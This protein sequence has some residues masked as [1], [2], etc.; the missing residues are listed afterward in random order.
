MK[1]ILKYMISPCDS[2]EA[3]N[4]Y[5]FFSNLP[6][7]KT[8]ALLLRP[9]K[10][11]DAAD[12]FRYASD[13]EVSKYVLWEPHRSVSDTRTYIRYVRRLYRRGLPSSW[14][15]VDLSSSVVIGSIGFMSY[16]AV[17]HS[18]EIGYSFSRE[19]WN[20]GYA[21]QAVNAVIHISFQS[22]PGL[23]RIEAQ[24]DV[25]NPA[26]GRVMMKCGMKYEGI[27]RSR[28]FNKSE[29]VDTALYA[30]LRS[31]LDDL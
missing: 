11:R 2:R 27:L 22:L 14:A 24:H 12:I 17:H 15:V 29:F 30:I 8:K 16:S 26:S 13:P 25:R 3:E 28:V 6:E 21:T 31:D 18:A 4:T 5:S 1:S 7:I 19:V 9:M 23:N 10:M 20:R